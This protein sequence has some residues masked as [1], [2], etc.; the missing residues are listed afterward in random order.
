MSRPWHGARPPGVL[1]PLL[2]WTLVLSVFW[3]WGR[4]LTGGPGLPW[5]AFHDRQEEVRS[6]EGPSGA[7]A[8]L[9]GDAPPRTVRIDSVGVAAEVLPRGLDED[10]G[11]EPPPFDAADAVGWWAG[12]ATPGAVGAAVLVGHVDTESA[13]AV[14]HALPEVEAGDP[15]LVERADGSVAVFTVRDVALVERA[16]FDPET[17][18]GPSAPGTAE[19]RLITCG[20]VYDRERGGYSANVVVSA[21]LTGVEPRAGVG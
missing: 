16:D 12:G 21:D 6:A 1:T 14:F 13:P 17:V 15:V 5:L 2:V 20:G 11:V 19:L 4:E 3:F 18:Y 9:P 8:P 7:V 10:G